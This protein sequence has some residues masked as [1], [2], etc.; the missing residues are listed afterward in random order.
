MG[1]IM[2]HLLVLCALSI[3]PLSF[4]AKASCY[5]ASVDVPNSIPKIYCLDSVLLVGLN[6]S[7]VTFGSNSNVPAHLDIKSI[8]YSN[9]DTIH[10]TAETIILNNR[11]GTCEESEF[12]TLT[13]NGTSVIGQNPEIQPKE[14]KLTV[15]YTSTHD[16][17]HSHPQSQTIHYNLL[18]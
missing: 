12:A 18:N 1:V 11:I 5:Q 9:E 2:K 8:T 3:L 10:F 17:C 16:T 13:L 14:L 6:T 15:D 4:M 7:L